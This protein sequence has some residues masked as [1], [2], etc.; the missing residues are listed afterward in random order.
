M[1]AGALWAVSWGL[2][3][4]A[5]AALLALP[6][7][8]PSDRQPLEY[9]AFEVIPAGEAPDPGAQ[10]ELADEPEPA[11]EPEPIVEPEPAAERTRVRA[12][13]PSPTRP[14]PPVDEEPP[15]EP[16][17]EP[18]LRTGLP[19]DDAALVDGD[20]A[21]PTGNTLD[22]GHDASLDPLALLRPPS[23]V[24]PA[25]P[26][27]A[28]V[29]PETP[30]VLLRSVQPHYPLWLQERG[31]DGRV[32]LLV[33][34][35]SNGRTGEVEVLEAAHPELEAQALAAIR[36]FRWSAARHEGAAV[37]SRVRIS[38]RFELR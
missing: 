14:E 36:R 13:R 18:E 23:P 24:A 2:A 32:V 6:L 27:R 19:L 3:I 31:V 15:V 25:P 37:E 4:L 20:V 30:A 12:P 26:G 28:S 10:S 21:V 9:V 8:V 38:F 29:E 11:A 1:R 22:P 33:Q 16:E 17:P 5:H 7:A 35:L 34:V